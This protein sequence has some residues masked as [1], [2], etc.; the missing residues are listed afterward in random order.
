MCN[1]EKLSF[2]E[3]KSTNPKTHLNRN[4]LHLNRNGSEK[5]SKNFS[6]FIKNISFLEASKRVMDFSSAFISPTAKDKPQA[7]TE[8]N[9]FA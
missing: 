1:K 7:G 3:H 9:L 4:R 6:N 5:F 2:L 8:A